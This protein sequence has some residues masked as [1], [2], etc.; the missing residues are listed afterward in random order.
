MF[1]DCRVLHVY[2]PTKFCVDS[3]SRFAFRARRETLT[4]S[5]TDAGDHA[6]VHGDTN[7]DTSR[8]DIK[9]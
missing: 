3:S 4:H 1:R 2:T 5:I 8:S 7:I 9:N 6:V